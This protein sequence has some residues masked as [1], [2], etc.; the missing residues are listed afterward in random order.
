M[1]FDLSTAK[2]VETQKQGGFDL[3]TAKPV[4]QPEQPQ[5]QS[6]DFPGAGFI[7]PAA[8]VASAIPAEILGGLSTLLPMA[9][10]DPDKAEA[11][12]NAMRELIQFQPKTEAG[13]EGLKSLGETLEPVTD[14]LQTV[15][16]KFS[17]SGA[18]TFDALGLSPAVGA[19]AGAALPEA[20]ASALGFSVAKKAAKIPSV[21]KVADT[22]NDLPLNAETAIK[23]LPATTA[24]AADNTKKIFT[25][26]SQLK[27]AIAKQIEFGGTDKNL[28]KFI[29]NG[30]GK[31]KKD[32]LAIES[33]KQGFDEGVIAAVKGSN[34]SDKSRLLKMV[35]IM[36]RGKNNALFATKHRPT[37]I[38]G[39]SLVSR[40]NYVRN[41]NKE[42][43]SRLDSI[44]KSL[45]GQRVDFSPAVQNFIKKLDD[46]GVEFDADITPK[47]GNSSIDGVDSAEKIVT[48]M[49]KRLKSGGRGQ[50]PDAY[51]LH[52]LKKFIDENVTFGKSGEGLKGKTKTILKELRHDIDTILDNN[53]KK[54]DQVNTRF[55]DTIESL[56]LLKDEA[57]KKIDILGKNADKSTGQLL[58]GMMSNNKGRIALVEAVDSLES[59]A[60]KY[61]AKFK[62]DIATQMLFAD[63][64]DSVFG[65]VAKTSLAG[66]VG[67]A[68]RKSAEVVTGRRGPLDA[69]LDLGEAGL[70]KVRGVDE[71]GA[72]KSIKELLRR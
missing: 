8:T 11:N 22:L 23:N 58:R 19:G 31:V 64:L 48:K 69:A 27:Q 65:P 29:V 49:I 12:L 7:E 21:K 67:K 24:K 6:E 55:A 72:F 46:I 63:E 28:A 40:I 52:I 35:N 30:A 16:D 36:E 51:D 18:Q 60:K 59:T 39:D 42:A 1:A 4:Q 5:Q 25:E 17:Q 45:K 3:S 9:M 62:D 61:G 10:G 15:E 50:A 71:K 53:F 38:A 68:T 57:G 44:A 37:D 47:F 56:N 43:G 20:I 2:P 34:A 14:V 13:K 26:Q 54:Y 33:I 41:V 66:E 32:K 70:N